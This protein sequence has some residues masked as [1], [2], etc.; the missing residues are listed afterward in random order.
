MEKPN[1]NKIIKN[2]GDINK[3]LYQTKQYLTQLEKYI[4]HL[5]LFNTNENAADKIKSRIYIKTVRIGAFWADS[6]TCTDII[7]GVL[8]QRG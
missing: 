6:D 2:T 7:D 5:E 4:K 1:R 3:E 8:K